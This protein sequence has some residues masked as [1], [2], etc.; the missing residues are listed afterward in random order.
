[1]KK[2]DGGSGRVLYFL[3]PKST[4]R[5]GGQKAP[6]NGSR[7]RFVRKMPKRFGA[8]RIL[9]FI[10]AGLSWGPD[11]ASVRAANYNVGALNV[12][13]FDQAATLNGSP[14]TLTPA[15]TLTMSGGT[16]TVT[17]GGTPY[18]AQIGTGPDALTGFL[19]GT[20]GTFTLSPDVTL[21][22]NVA[23]G[24]FVPLTQNGSGT[25]NLTADGTQNLRVTQNEGTLNVSGNLTTLGDIL[26]NGTATVGGDFV[27]T[28]ISGEVDVV[29]VRGALSVTG[30]YRDLA[31]QTNVYGSLTAQTVD[32]VGGGLDV[33]AGGEFLVDGEAIFSNQTA[34]INKGR[35]QVGA[36]SRLESSTIADSGTMTL[37]SGTVITG[38]VGNTGV[39]TA[40]GSIEFS[41]VTNL[42]TIDVSG[43]AVFGGE[44]DAY[45]G[46]ITVNGSGTFQTQTDITGASTLKVTGGAEF[47]DAL[48]IIESAAVD[49]GGDVTSDADIL[50]TDGTL[51]SGGNIVTTQGISA[52]GNSTL[53]LSN[54]LQGANLGYLEAGTTINLASTAQIETDLS[55]LAAVRSP[56]LLVHMTADGSTD[57]FQIDGAPTDAA[58]VGAMFGTSTVLRQIYAV[59]NGAGYDIYGM[60]RSLGDYA[61]DE[62]LEKPAVDAGNAVDDLFNN[63]PPSD[64][65]YDMAED[66]LGQTDQDAINETLYNLAGG[67][68]VENIFSMTMVNLGQAGSPFFFGGAAGLRQRENRCCAS[69]LNPQP[70]Q[71]DDTE[72]W[73]A[74]FYQSLD[75]GGNFYQSGFNTH[76]TGFMVGV[77]KNNTSRLAAGVLFAYGAPRLNQGGKL[78]GYDANYRSDLDLDDFQFAGHVEYETDSRLRLSVFAGGGTQR[79]NLRRRAWGTA[80]NGTVMDRSFTGS[81]DGNTL[82]VTTYLERPVCLNSQVVL[83]PIAGVDC[84]FAW[85]SSFEENS[86]GTGDW[87]AM[88]NLSEGNF[89]SPVT[90][91]KTD[92]NRILGRVG[93]KGEY[94]DPK[95]GISLQA[96]Y[97]TQ[98]GGEDYAVVP[99]ST[100][101]GALNHQIYGFGIGRDSLN[102]GGG[103]WRYLNPTQ[104]MV[105]AAH[106]N[107]F[108]LSEAKASNVT[109]SFSWRY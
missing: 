19:W 87:E 67:Y 77:K 72:V 104:N 2:G 6:R 95:G 23:S 82:S 13:T 106:Y 100:L 44:L 108:T 26:I 98:L 31:D 53:G 22:V 9:F 73:G 80:S 40:E 32:F 61:Q 89:Y 51:L 91:Q 65:A 30:E 62:G 66:L 90:Y 15:D 8:A 83:S 85:L 97:G 54:R 20:G 49:V 27:A 105:A 79:L 109:A 92:Y 14:V 45:G 41:H 1:M 93:L 76:E 55:G 63:T 24:T 25:L 5:T 59:D 43:D 56:T 57:D 21:D 70:Y 36:N 37:G 47:D 78:A 17:G 7:P 58:A 4:V 52:A 74:P 71:N 69:C 60:T 39:I 38:V 12:V 42:G 3:Q 35:F 84:M 33:E 64:P 18:S 28:S 103:F 46:S 107:Y 48:S 75:A 34:I 88:T 86:T 50:L 11:A 94:T 81:A 10:L 16:M 68:G 29:N 102:L 99:V 101:G 96:F